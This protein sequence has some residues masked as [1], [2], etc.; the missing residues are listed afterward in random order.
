MHDVVKTAA[1][2]LGI[3][4]LAYLVTVPGRIYDFVV[5]PPT[6]EQ[7]A[8]PGWTIQPFDESQSTAEFQLYWGSDEEAAAAYI[9]AVEDMSQQ[10]LSA[11]AKDYVREHIIP[12]LKQLTFEETHGGKY[13][14]GIYSDNFNHRITIFVD[15]MHTEI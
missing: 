8:G 4:A 3:V 12:R 10:E 13:P 2:T 11:A 15:S 6:V 1:Y 9:A 14:A 5:G 7:A